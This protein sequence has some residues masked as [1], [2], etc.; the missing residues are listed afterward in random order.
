[1]KQAFRETVLRQGGEA[2][3]FL[4]RRVIYYSFFSHEAAKTQSDQAQ[5]CYKDRET[6]FT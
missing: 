6:Q 3:P 2:M 5:D 4:S 1:M